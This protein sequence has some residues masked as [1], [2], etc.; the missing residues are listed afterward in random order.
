MVKFADKNRHQVFIEPEG[1]YTNEMYIGGMS[2]S[3]PEDVQYEMYRSVKGLENAR[4]VRNAYAIDMT[5]LT[6][7]SFILPW[8][9]RRSKGFSQEDSLT[10]VQAMRKRLPRDWWQGSMRLWRSLEE[11]CWCWTVQNPISEC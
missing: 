7:I 4:I 1:L 10:E 8:N 9:L 2:S 11:K 6:L 5:V 3:L